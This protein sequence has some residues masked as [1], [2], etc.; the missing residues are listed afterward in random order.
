MTERF[1]HA[2]LSGHKPFK[3]YWNYEDG[4]LLLG[5]KR[6]FEATGRAEYAE[7]V[8]RYLSQRVEPDGV[9]P[10]YLTDAYSL[11]SFN[12]GKTLFFAAE[13]TGEERYRKAADRL[14]EQIRSHPRTPS[15]CCWHK[16]IYP[17]QVWIDGIYMAA[18]FFAEY[19]AVTGD[20]RMLPEIEHWF[21]VAEAHL[22]D[23]ESGLY[24]HAL[25]EARVQAWADPKTGLSPSHWLRAEGWYLMA[26][27]DTA[28]LLPEQCTALR[29]KLHDAL[30]NA[31]EALLPYRTENGLYLQ[32]IDRKDVPENYEETSGSLMAAYAMI[33]GASAG[34][35]DADFYQAGVTTLDAVLTRHLV[36]T[37]SGSSL[38]GICSAAGLGGIPHRDGTCAYYLSEPVTADDPKGVGALMLTEAAKRT[39]QH[40]VNLRRSA[41]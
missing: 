20:D 38:T 15:G 35:L 31:C 2:Y 5:C 4:C 28:A 27:Y 25:D 29:G 13:L 34:I 21:D 18:P 26:L 7:F 23:P 39:A 8:L 17:D 24:Y 16:R 6:M 14:A 37:P 9:I 10:S 12:C 3:N 30:R 22:R 1:F 11:D 33:Q 41:V 36:K 19:A 32:V 40:T